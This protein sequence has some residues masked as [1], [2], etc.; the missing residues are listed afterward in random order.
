FMLPGGWITNVAYA[1]ISPKFTHVACAKNVAYHALSF[2]GVYSLFAVG[3]NTRGV[4]SAML[5]HRQ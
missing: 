2:S 4:L 5:Q 1:D 3:D